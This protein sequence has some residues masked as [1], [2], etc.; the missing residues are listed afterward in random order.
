MTHA[1]VRQMWAQ[2]I[3]PDPD[4][5]RDWQAGLPG[6]VLAACLGHLAGERKSLG[7]ARAAC[8]AWR[9]QADACV[10]Q[11]TLRCGRA[12]SG[13]IRP[14]LRAPAAGWG[15]PGAAARAARSAKIS[16]CGRA[17]AC[18]SRQ[19]HHI[20]PTPC[21]RKPP[22]RATNPSRHHA[23]V[24]PCRRAPS[25]SRCW[26]P[27][28]QALARFGGLERLELKGPYIPGDRARARSSLRRW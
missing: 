6:E 26:P 9:A 27:R 22:P 13:P 16:L 8:A 15:G 3:C 14:T 12:R 25:L 10:Q 4:N 11:L 2:W 7:A 18:T 5:A 28:L 1:A 21:A 17:A 19:H 24:M 23:P 20:K